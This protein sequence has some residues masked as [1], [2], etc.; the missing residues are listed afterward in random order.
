MSVKALSEN[1]KARFDYEIKETIE[2]GIELRGFEVKSVK[3]GRM[4]IVG[5]NVIVRGGEAW[6][7]NSQIPPYQQNNTPAGYDPSRTRR[8]LLHKKEIAH[9]VG[10]VKEKTVSLIPLRVVVKNGIVKLEIGL[11]RSRKKHDKRELLKK[12]ATIREMRTEKENP[13]QK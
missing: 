11:G 4:G 13:S 12:R 1:R 7:V 9:L 3:L 10:S 8:L 5:S 2:A 6:L